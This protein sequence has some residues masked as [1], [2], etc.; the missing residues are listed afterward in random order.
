[1]ELYFKESQEM[2]K[3]DGAKPDKNGSYL[4]LHVLPFK[5]Y[6]RNDLGLGDASSPIFPWILLLVAGLIILIACSNFVNLSLANSFAR[7]REIG[8]RKTLGSSTRQLVGQL[9]TESFVLCLIALMLGLGL[10]WLLLGEYNA[11]MNYRL[12]IAE[13]FTP[14][15]LIIFVA[16]FLG[17]TILAGG[18]PAWRIAQ[19]NIIQTLKGTATMRS[20]K[21]RNSLTIAQF[22]IA[23]ILIISTIIIGLQLR[24]VNLRPLGFN[25]KT[26][27]SVPIGVGIEP[28]MALQKMRNALAS[29]PWV[30]TVSAA[31]INLGRG[32]D[33][34]MSTSVFGFDFNGRQVSTNFMRIDYDYLKTLDIKLLSGR[35]FDRS[36]LTDTS[37]IL[38]NKQMAIQ[39]G[40]ED[41]VLNETI[42]LAGG[43][44]IIGI[45]DDFNFMKLDQKVQPLTLSINPGIFHVQYIFVRVNGDQLSEQL[46]KVEKIWKTVNPKA[47]IA[48]SFLDE[49]MQDL[50][51]EEQ[52]FVKII[53]SGAIIAIAISALGLFALALMTINR[54]VKEIGIRKVLGSSVGGL[55]LLLSKDFLK[56]ILIAFVI[57]APIA[58]WIMQRWLQ[59][60]VYRITIEW[61]MFLLAGLIAFAIALLTITWQTLRAARGNPV[62]SLRD[63]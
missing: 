17:I 49:N 12:K 9:W 32:R 27:I 37:A 18:Y 35:D 30:T 24:Y 21:L 51:K 61:W 41:K 10:A 56:L 28:E 52:R 15:N 16:L 45:I 8:T 1:M 23:T 53:I 46:A 50:Y 36:Y 26:V 44:K 19:S 7:N 20:S 5:D 34:S 3:R 11:L 43:I 39:L 29:E 60:F 62:D 58:W 40:G 55:M 38:I 6:H 33:G 31:D 14:T 22:T 25:K 48:A 4:S 59:H 42:K 54:R 57:A 2:L 13:L 63:E 47:T